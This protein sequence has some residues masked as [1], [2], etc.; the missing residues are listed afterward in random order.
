M[1]LLLI[2]SIH[3]LQNTFLRLHILPCL[4]Q[5]AKTTY[6]EVTGMYM[7]IKGKLMFV[8]EIYAFSASS[9][10]TKKSVENLISLVGEPQ[11]IEQH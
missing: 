2:R 10:S 3:R 6:N 5:K 1:L 11:P 8:E 7:I 4:K 9:A